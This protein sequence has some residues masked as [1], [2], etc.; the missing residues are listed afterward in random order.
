MGAQV[1]YTNERLV[2]FEPV[3]DIAITA[4]DQLVATEIGGDEVALGVDEL[5]VLALAMALARG[6]SRVSGAAEL[7]EKESNRLSAI[8]QNL[9]NQGVSV[10]E[11]DDGFI[12]SGSQHFAGGGS[13]ATH[14]DHRMAMTGLVAQL[15]A[16]KPLNLGDT[17]CINISYPGFVEDLDKCI[18]QSG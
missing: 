9:S 1:T 14:E 3:C 10:E 5:P 4:P 11:L 7:K 16:K 13:W 15:V 6:R 8:C 18:E 17:A 12:I 2:N